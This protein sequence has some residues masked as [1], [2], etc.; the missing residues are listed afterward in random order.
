[1]PALL[2]RTAPAAH[3]ALPR[4]RTAGVAGF[5][6]WL[7]ATTSCWAQAA[8]PAS[9]AATPSALPAKQAIEEVV[10]TAQLRSQKI[11]RVP[12]SI[13]AFSSA[14]IK[15]TGSQTIA[16]LQKYTPGLT[17]DD[18]STTQPVFSLRGISPDDFGV[19]TDPAV[20]LYV[21]GFYSARSG[22]ALVFF[23]DLSRVEV[24]K[25]PQG[26]LFGRNTAAGA[27][28]II[29]NKPVDKYEGSID[30]KL[31]NYGKVEE[32]IMLNVPVSDTF[33]VR[34]DGLINR[35]A[36]YLTNSYNGDQLNNEHNESVRVAAKYQPSPDTDVLLAWDHDNTN[37]TPPTALGIGPYANNGGNPYGP[38]YDRVINGQESRRLDDVSLTAHHQFDGFTLTSLSA[39][40]FFSTQNRESETGSADPSRYFDT[41]NVE[42]NHNFY[43]ELR[44]N[45]VWDNLTWAAG[46][47]YYQERAKQ[48]SIATALTNSI[49]TLIS[50]LAGAPAVFAQPICNFV[51]LCGLNEQPWTE[52]MNNIGQ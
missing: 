44:L 12:I 10:V 50:T 36:G 21:D 11:Q 41:E 9:P 3:R 1:M 40:K 27:I 19:G 49:D 51:G 33:Y 45:G 34:V 8:A 48:Q 28:S 15:Q 23:D 52:A 42:N 32:T 2:D 4:K 24:L 5:G 37:V 39:Y 18:T 25:G 17:V 47:S 20:G 35:R 29:T 30:E 7:M 6:A 16:D 22:E 38:I 43:Q 31:G 26:T 46:A 14:F 13:N